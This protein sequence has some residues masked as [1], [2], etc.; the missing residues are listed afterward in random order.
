MIPIHHGSFALSYERVDEPARWLAE[1]IAER[2][3]QDHVRLLEPG[4]SEV[5]V[6]PRRETAP[7]PD[8]KV[9]PVTPG[10][11]GGVVMAPHTDLWMRSIEV[12]LDDLAAAAPC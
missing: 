4:Q 8:V 1:L 12:A 7:P 5:F 10:G 9:D 11:D 3:L 6:A 2:G